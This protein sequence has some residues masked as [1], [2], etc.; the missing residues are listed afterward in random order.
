MQDNLIKFAVV[1]HKEP[2][3]APGHDVA[4]ITVEVPTKHMPKLEGFEDKYEDE[5]VSRR[6]VSESTIIEHVVRGHRWAMTVPGGALREAQR[7]VEKL[8]RHIDSKD[9]HGVLQHEG[10]DELRKF[11][12]PWH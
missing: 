5:K 6:L 7:I 9:E 10:P 4:Y 11:I 2:G 3:F 1:R 12:K 8:A